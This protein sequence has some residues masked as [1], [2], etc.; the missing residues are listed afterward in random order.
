[1]QEGTIFTPRTGHAVSILNG[2]FYL[3]G[4]ADNQQI[5]NDLYCFDV[6]G[7]EWEE[8]HTKGTPPQPRSGSKTCVIEQ[9][10]YFFGGYTK[11]NGKYFSD[12][13]TYSPINN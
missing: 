2:I 3:F 12:L 1:M 11:K 5:L 4:G 9:K 7:K 6:M 13:F 8:I 10:I